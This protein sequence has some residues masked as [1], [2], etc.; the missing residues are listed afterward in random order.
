MICRMPGHYFGISRG[1]S[2]GN[3]LLRLKLLG[4]LTCLEQVLAGDL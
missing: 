3:Q 2:F 4:I 1:L